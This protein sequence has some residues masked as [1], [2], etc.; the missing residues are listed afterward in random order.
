MEELLLKQSMD[1]RQSFKSVDHRE[2]IH[3]EERLKEQNREDELEALRALQH[4]IDC[5]GFERY[6]MEV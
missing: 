6:A 2:L 3:L 5:I 4:D 1:C